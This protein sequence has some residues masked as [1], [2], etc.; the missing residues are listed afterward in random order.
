MRKP[1][2]SSVQRMYMQPTYPTRTR[3]RLVQNVAVPKV[4]CK[5]RTQ[6]QKMVLVH[7][8][9]RLGNEYGRTDYRFFK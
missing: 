6:M 2:C 4:A 9:E 8:E 3:F 5:K 7:K 1:R